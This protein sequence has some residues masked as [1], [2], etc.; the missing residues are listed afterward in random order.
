MISTDWRIA[1]L[2]SKE[3]ARMRTYASVT[4]ELH[5]IVLNKKEQSLTPSQTEN[6]FIYPTNSWTRWLTGFYAHR[7]ATTLR[8]RGITLVTSQDPF[9][10]GLVAYKIS[11]FL[12]APLQLQLHTDFL[13]PYYAAESSKNKTR[14]SIARKLMPLANCIRV[15]SKR[16]KEGL[17]QQ[18]ELQSEP[19][20][21]PIHLDIPVAMLSSHRD[22]LKRKYPQFGTILLIV[23]RLEREKNIFMAL[24][25]LKQVLP[26][27]PGVGL[28]IVGD[29]A[30][31]K[32]LEEFTETLGLK[33]E[34]VFEGWE[35]QTIPYF[36]SADF[37]LNTSNYE[38]YCRTLM[39]AAAASCPIVTTDVGIVGEVLN[40][41]NALVSPPGNIEAFQANLE[42][43]L[44]YREE[45][46]IKSERAREAVTHYMSFTESDRLEIFRRSWEAC[47]KK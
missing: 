4:D 31:R 3:H 11:R 9:E 6:L 8:G 19:V 1:V 22:F 28:V 18:L 41:S 24:L 15:V 26:R 23:A 40:E 39:E 14:V 25:A 12:N 5:I 7:I 46:R 44:T 10:T 32:K 35:E 13:S 47:S 29:G 27:N 20:V 43:A 33:E 38:G 21:L 17:Q 34:V 30:L 16:L 37:F 36:L 42:H 2:G 45:M